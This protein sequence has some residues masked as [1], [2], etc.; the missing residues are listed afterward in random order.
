MTEAVDRAIPLLCERGFHGTSI[1]DLAEVMQ[2]TMGSLYKAFGDKRGVFL[3]ALERESSLRD[4]RLREVLASASS[5]RDKIHAALLFYV[6][7][8]HGTAGIQ[9][10]LTI[11]TAVELAT[12]DREIAERA[13][14]VF[15]RRESHLEELLRLG[16]TDGSIS[17]K[18]DSRGTARL[19]LCVLQGLRVIGKT[20]RTREEFIAVVDAAM[21][22]LD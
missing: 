20:G 12:S 6:G 21:R 1:D 7:L 18:I 19:M 22:T 9:G 11:S 8:S 13:E 17:I 16:Q 5:G 4:A 2:L 15:K 14:Q 10:C 3:A